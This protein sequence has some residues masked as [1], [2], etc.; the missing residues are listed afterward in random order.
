MNELIEITRNADDSPC[1]LWIRDVPE[2]DNPETLADY[3]RRNAP[4]NEYEI[5]ETGEIRATENALR[6][7]IVALRA[8]EKIEAEYNEIEAEY[9]ALTDG[10]SQA[11]FRIHHDELITISAAA[12]ILGVKLSAISNRI[13]R[14]QLHAYRDP[15]EPNPTKARRVLRSEVL[16]LKS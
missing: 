16:A 2:F 12:E 14:G 10:A 15:A 1:T 8:D 7:A 5:A 4:V 11:R 6:L 3:L 13:D 9:N